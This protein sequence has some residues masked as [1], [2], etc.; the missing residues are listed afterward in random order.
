[1]KYIRIEIFSLH[2]SQHVVFE[3]NYDGYKRSVI[4][5]DE[6]V[7]PLFVHI[8]DCVSATKFY[9]NVGVDRQEI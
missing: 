7:V 5:F 2:V 9:V 6:R 1:M 8:S 3:R 4:I